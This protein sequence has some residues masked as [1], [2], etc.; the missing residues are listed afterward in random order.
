MAVTQN[1]IAA[2]TNNACFIL[3]TG[4]GNRVAFDI[5]LKV[6]NLV[7]SIIFT[8]EV[9]KSHNKWM[10]YAL[11]QIEKTINQS[12]EETVAAIFNDVLEATDSIKNA[13]LTSS[14]AAK[15]YISSLNLGGGTYLESDITNFTV[16]NYHF[17][18]NGMVQSVEDFTNQ[19]GTNKSLLIFDECSSEKE[20][21]H[22]NY[23]IEKLAYVLGNELSRNLQ[24][25]IFI[26]RLREEFSAYP[27]H[28]VS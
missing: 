15:A 18:V 28:M 7:K 2:I 25:T 27:L 26:N 16:P 22:N 3:G 6:P 9:L 20:L 19:V 4:I 24:S 13:C 21:I 5:G 23:F 10:N 8:G 14:H 12:A 11:N 1:E 17:F